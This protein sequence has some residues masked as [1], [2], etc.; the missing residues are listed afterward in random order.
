MSVRLSRLRSMQKRRW[1][2][3]CRWAGNF[4]VIWVGLVTKSVQVIVNYKVSSDELTF[5]EYIVCSKY[6]TG[7]TVWTVYANS[8]VFGGTVVPTANNLTACQTSC[9]NT[10]NCTGI[11]YNPGNPAGWRCFQLMDASA[12]ITHNV[13]SG[14]SHYDVTNNCATGRLSTH[15]IVIIMIIIIIIDLLST[16]TIDRWTFHNTVKR[17]ARLKCLISISFCF[18]YFIKMFVLLF[19]LIHK[20]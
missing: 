12:S 6:S 5:D 1:L 9:L 11:D 7:C 2:Y 18:C 14:V 17:Q 20:V 15:C 3:S 10:T 16:Y 13:V 8:N 4:S 19:R